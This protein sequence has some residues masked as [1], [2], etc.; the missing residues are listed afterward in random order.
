MS[1]E[2]FPTQTADTQTVP[3]LPTQA[4]PTVDRSAA[5][6]NLRKDLSRFRQDQRL[7]AQ[8]QIVSTGISALDDILPDQGLQR[9]T[10][11]E[12]I[13][14]E[15]GSG[16]ATLAM[17]VAGKAQGDGPLIIVDRQRR[18]YP[19]AFSAVGVCLEKTILVQPKS[20]ADELWTVEQSLRCP[21]VGAVMCR[22][23]HLKTQEFRRLQLAAEVGT[24]IGLLLRSA[25]AQRQSGWA[26]M[27]LLV[28][29]RPSLPQ[30]FCRRLGVRC[31][32]AKGGMAGQTVE[33]ELSDETNT[34]RLAAELSH[35]TSALRS[36]EP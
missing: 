33:L 34:V 25:D 22:M 11:C 28:S 29:P 35:S 16:A 8:R 36:T 3:A 21:G 27:R 31:L 1:A 24:A 4:L 9:G 26:D 18:F 12:W 14:A 20:R 7:D 5:I 19:P 13:V 30:S 2:S 6:Q 23:D 32:Y 17:R 10:L 15:P